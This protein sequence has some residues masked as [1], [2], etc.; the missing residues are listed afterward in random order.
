VPKTKRFFDVSGLLISLDSQKFYF[1]RITC[2][3]LGVFLVAM[4]LSTV[5]IAQGPCPRYAAGSAVQDPPIIY[6]Q[7]GKLEVDF[8]YET[9]LD[10]SGTARF[11]FKTL[12]GKQSPTLYLNPGDQLVLRV[13]NLVPPDAPGL[14]E[15][16]M[17]AGGMEVSAAKVCGAAVMTPSSVNVHYHGTNVSPTCHSDE[18]IHTLIN[19]GDSFE[20]RVKF[21]SDEPPGLYWYHPHVH[22]ISEG[23]VQGGAT[24]LIVIGGIQNVQP[25]VAGLPQR[26]LI[27]RDTEVPGEPP[28]PAPAYNLSLNYVPV[29]FPTYPPAVITVRPQ[30]KQFW[31]VANTASDTILDIALLYDGRPQKLELVGLD[32]VPTGSQDGTRLGKLVRVDHVRIPT[33]GR[34]EFIMTTP[35]RDVG[36]AILMTRAVNTGPDGDSDPARPLAVLNVSDEP[37]RVSLPTVPRFQ[38]LTKRQRFEGLDHEKVTATRKLY[39]SEDSAD[40]FFITVQG[41]EPKL[42]RPDDPPS[43]VTR[44]GAVEEWT[45]ENR[46]KENH[47]FHIHQLHFL[48][49]KV[50]GIPVPT[51]KR[52]FLDTV[53][54]P[55]WS[56]TGPY[57]SVTLRLDFRGPDIGDF[58][59]HCHILEHED[60][61]MMAIVRVLPR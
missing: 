25:R 29:P 9:E 17:A 46:A 52:Q 12:D 11:C 2:S 3:G 5:C 42:F 36:Q 53:D 44:Q 18:V 23:A 21:P 15:M 26:F 56:G 22:G 1:S 43:I 49:E 45:I 50:N 51:G 4:V 30:E 47:E 16:K 7:N 32:G 60:G 6:S 20:Y 33:A 61:G 57:P 24:G 8:T 59:Y 41:Q 34:V 54:V 37:V 48:L 39:F 14:P 10:D 13:K 58:V 35:S 55:F 28:P 31:R 38:V 40:H 27:V 19:S